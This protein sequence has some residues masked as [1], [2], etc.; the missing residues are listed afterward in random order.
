[1]LRMIQGK[2]VAIPPLPPLQ[3]IVRESTMR[4]RGQPFGY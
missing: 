3:V 4:R 2:T 1:V